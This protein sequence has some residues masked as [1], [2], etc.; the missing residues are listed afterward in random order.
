MKMTSSFKKGEIYGVETGDYVG[1][2]FVVVDIKKDIIG[3]L[4]LPY[5]ENIKVPFETFDHGRNTGIIKLIEK[6]PRSVFK[7]SK[8]QYKKNENSNHR[9]EQFDTPNLVD[10]K[11]PGKEV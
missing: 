7:V 2:M 11:E 6:L 3:C 9:F 5:M 1:Q 10:S 8:A 4:R